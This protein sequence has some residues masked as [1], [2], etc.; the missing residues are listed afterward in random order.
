M[1]IT[2][3]F[4]F[5]EQNVDLRECLINKRVMIAIYRS[6][7]KMIQ[8]NILLPITFLYT[9]KLMGTLNNGKTRATTQRGIPQIYDCL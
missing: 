5:V 3:L 9:G 2:L 1:L 8:K 6:P 7:V 4:I